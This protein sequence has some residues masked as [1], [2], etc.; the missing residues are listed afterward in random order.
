V[1]VLADGV[2]GRPHRLGAGEA[3]AF[4]KFSSALGI[5]L[6]TRTEGHRKGLELRRGAKPVAS[7]Y[8]TAPISAYFPL[9][10]EQQFKAAVK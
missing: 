7:R 6:M 1:A 8:F 2:E 4:Q 10:C 3:D 5:P 9:F